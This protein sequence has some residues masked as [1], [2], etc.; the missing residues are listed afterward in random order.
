MPRVP[1]T[2]NTV[3]KMGL[4]GGEAVLIKRVGK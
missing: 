3:E 1:V 4:V 2:E